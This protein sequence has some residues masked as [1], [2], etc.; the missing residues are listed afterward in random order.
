MNLVRIHS[1]IVLDDPRSARL[2]YYSR[3]VDRTDQ[4]WVRLGLNALTILFGCSRRTLS[5][6]VIRAFERGFF[7]SY[8][9]G[10]DFLYLKYCSIKDLK[11]KVCVHASG[12]VS[13]DRILSLE[14]LKE[15]AVHLS[16]LRQ[17]EDSEYRI[18]QQKVPSRNQLNPYDLSG[19]K[20]AKGCTKINKDNLFLKSRMNSPSGSQISVASY[21]GVS[22]QTV[23]KYA[24]SLP[25]IHLWK[26]VKLSP[27]GK[28][29]S[30]HFQSYILTKNGHKRRREFRRLPNF[31]F[32]PE[33][34][35]PRREKRDRYAIPDRPAFKG[36]KKEWETKQQIR[37]SNN[38][39]LS[40]KLPALGKS[41]I[42]IIVHDYFCYT[43]GIEQADFILSFDWE[44]MITLLYDLLEKSDLKDK[45]Y[46]YNLVCQVS[47]VTPKDIDLNFFFS[48]PEVLPK[49]EGLDNSS[50][51]EGVLSQGKV[52]SKRTFEDKLNDLSKEK[53]Q[54]LC[55]DLI[56]ILKGQENHDFFKASRKM[57]I[58]SLI[59]TVSL[60]DWK[61]LNW[62]MLLT[63]RASKN[64]VPATRQ[65]KSGM[66]SFQPD[67]ASIKRFFGSLL[68]KE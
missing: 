65:M 64:L 13:A 48:R 20:S 41:L 56:F 63:K 15:T 9:I 22:R 5:Q 18:V 34:L 58:D 32:N 44:D 11:E 16:L 27:E 35:R 52:N 1:K 24:Q 42:S 10:K 50:D 40:D 26:V 6:Q 37:K 29:P 36:D 61:G 14:R 31:Y 57:I 3:L 12:E 19:S 49:E 33:S 38:L 67:E 17:Q 4:G 53:L 43:L 7:H 59:N 51:L 54:Q 30:H 28:M 25:H 2:Y 8:E 39:T 60:L 55:F 68:N 21:L 23:V 46:L 62:L 47:Q 45:T 66:V